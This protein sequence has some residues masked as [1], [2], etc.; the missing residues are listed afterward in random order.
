MDEAVINILKSAGDSYDSPEK[1][2]WRRIEDG[3]EIDC[4]SMYGAPKITLEMLTKLA[5][6]FGT[7]KIDV[8]NSTINEQGCETCDYG[9]SY[10]HT[11]QIKFITKNMPVKED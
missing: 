2:E 5:E 6:Y 10:G 7:T 9:S 4:S 11:I 1:I 8:D 3:I